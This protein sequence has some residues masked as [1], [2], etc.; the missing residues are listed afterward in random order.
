MVY[1]SH[2]LVTVL[3]SLLFL[4]GKILR[5]ARFR[6]GW[7]IEHAAEKLGVDWTTLSRWERDKQTPHN[8]NLYK[9]IQVYQDPRIRLRMRIQEMVVLMKKYDTWAD[10]IEANSRKA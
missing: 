4:L 5:D 6:C 8:H 7:T 2:M 3:V 1:P 10:F 9:A